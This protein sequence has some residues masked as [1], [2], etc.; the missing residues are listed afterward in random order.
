MNDRLLELVEKNA[1]LTNEQLSGMTGCSVQ[2]IQDAK[3]RYEQE[4][5][6]LGYKAVINWDKTDREYV[7][8]LIEIKVVPQRGRGFD[9]IAERI[10][11][12]PEVKNLYLMSGDF[13]LACLIEGETMKDVALFVSE[14]LAPMESVKSTSTHFILKK[15]KESNVIYE[16]EKEDT[17]EV[18][19]L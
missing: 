10:Y 8:A 7:T 2:D 1:M 9:K 13:D 12:Y 16:D 6:I 17:R 4:N 11:R 5:I 15:Y 3:N 14:K 18:I 19:T